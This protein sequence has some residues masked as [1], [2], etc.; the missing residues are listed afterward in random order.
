M[1]PVVV[2]GAGVIGI[3][4][5]REMAIQG[6]QPIILE[7][8]I[9]YGSVTSSR[10]SEVVHGGIYYRKNSLK[11]QLC[12][13]GRDLLYAYCAKYNVAHRKMGKLIFANCDSQR[14]ALD[15]ICDNARAC[16]AGDVQRLGAEG[17]RRL[18]PMLDCVE[19]VLSPATGIVDSHGLMRTLLGE[20]EA[21]G[22]MLVART[23]VEAI[24]PVAGG[25]AI[26]IAGETGPA[27]V[28]ERVINCAGLGAQQLAQRTRGLD[29]AHVPPLHYAKGVYF[30]Y[31][32]RHPFG[33]LIYPVPEPGGLGVHLTIDLAGGA[34]FGPDV[35]WVDAPD[36][37]VP[38]AKHARFAA[39]AQRI[40]P[41][42][43]PSRLHPAYAG[44]RPKL[45]GPEAPAAD[46]VISGPQDHGLPG[47]V[48]L[49][50]IESPGLTASLAIGEHVHKMLH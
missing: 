35:E 37:A 22:G 27:L 46:F 8:E 30:A 15:T 2:I 50:G 26:H 44:V 34:R 11:A 45:A 4:V 3:A 42:L 16:G 9:C 32:G 33:R 28:A 21:L 40:W 49:F 25:W 29:A 17:A 10:N 7:R 47:L 5:A 24:A 18:E 38:A 43:D 1:V 36:Y 48:N 13:R 31:H 41:G 6:L 19:A 14:P 39:A 23:E 12:V 20:T